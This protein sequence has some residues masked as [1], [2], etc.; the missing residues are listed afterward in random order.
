[1]IRS[2]SSVDGANDANIVDRFL[3]DVFQGRFFPRQSDLC[4]PASP[5]IA[6]AKCHRQ[7]M[8]DCELVLSSPVIHRS[9]STALTSPG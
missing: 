1:M 2:C 5:I 6:T 7:G 3:R 8:K 4:L 9:A